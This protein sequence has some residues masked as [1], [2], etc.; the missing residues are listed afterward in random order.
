M[1]FFLNND[2]KHSD[3]KKEKGHAK[4]GTPVNGP[5]A[6]SLLK[7]SVPQWLPPLDHYSLTHVQS[8]PTHNEGGLTLK[9]N[10]ATWLFP[11]LYIKQ[12]DIEPI[13]KQKKINWECL[14]F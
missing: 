10:M 12:I 7:G 13:N 2:G 6:H 5:N 9:F 14:K 3:L 8:L 4:S 1:D 11:K